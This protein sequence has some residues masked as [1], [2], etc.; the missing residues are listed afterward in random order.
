MTEMAIHGICRVTFLSLEILLHQGFSEN[1]TKRFNK[2]FGTRF[3]IIMDIKPI[4]LAVWERRFL[5][6]LFLFM[7]YKSTKYTK[8]QSIILC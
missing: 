4:S 1:D 7:N 5:L 3:E 8:G 6:R 2:Q